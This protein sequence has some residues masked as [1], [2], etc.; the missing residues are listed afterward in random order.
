MARTS[1]RQSRARW[2]LDHHFTPREAELLS[3]V[4]RKTPALLAM[5]RDR[6]AR[7]ERFLQL[8]RTRVDKGKWRRDQVD[9]KWLGN[10]SRLYSK[11]GWRVKHGPVPYEGVVKL[12]KSSTNPW[13]MYRA[14]VAD[15][16]NKKHKSP[17]E[18]KQI[19]SGKTR[20]EKGLVFVQGAEQA[21]AAGKSVGKGMIRQ[22]ISE[23]ELAIKGARGKRRTQLTIEKR[24]L[25]RLL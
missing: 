20:L 8:A 4:P 6:D 1:Q 3:A 14:Y 7:W 16:P 9:G 12:G 2:L 19:K 24:R 17:W 5:V 23:K 15:R 13:A 11:M 25:E 21:E 10:L 18:R 22:W